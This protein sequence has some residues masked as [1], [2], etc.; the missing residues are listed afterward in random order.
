MTWKRTSELVTGDDVAKAIPAGELW[1]GFVFIA[2][3]PAPVTAVNHIV[4]CTVRRIDDT[5]QH[6]AM[7]G[8]PV[9]TYEQAT[10]AG[11]TAGNYLTPSNVDTYADCVACVDKFIGYGKS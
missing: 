10:A 9:G 2:D 7:C 4:S 1:S 3:K 11:M 8:V 5:W 6:L